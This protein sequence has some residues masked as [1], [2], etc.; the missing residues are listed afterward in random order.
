MPSIA[1]C[2]VGYLGQQISD[3]HEFNIKDASLIIRTNFEGP[4][5]IFSELANR[6]VN[7]GHGILIGISSVAGERG[8][9]SNY[10]YG[11][12]KAGFTTF[13]SGLR[14]KLFRNNIHVITVL[15]GYVNTK[16]IKHITTSRKL[17]AE[18]EQVANK[19][20]SAV[21][22]KKNIIYV[23]S[24][25]RIIMIIIKSIPERIFVRLNI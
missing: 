12:A 9:Q 24:I 21:K 18:P 19:I 2:S 4:A 23:N 15:P 7:Q 20:Y 13:L 6:F 22:S 5:S 8:R 1:L 16:L 11:S 10:L 14:N 3:N 17:T 25:W